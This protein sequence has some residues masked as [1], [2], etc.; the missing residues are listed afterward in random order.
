ML[1][2]S[3]LARFLLFHIFSWGLCLGLLSNS[4]GQDTTPPTVVSTYPA[5]GATNVRL[6]LESVSITFDR[7]M[8][9]GYSIS[10][11]FPYDS[12]SWSTDGQTFTLLRSDLSTPLLAG[13]TYTFTLNKD[14]STS[15]RD[16][17][18]VP[19]EEYTFSFTT[20]TNYE[21]L[22]IPANPASV[23]LSTVIAL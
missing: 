7:R 22:K 14:S 12:V 13:T 21:L 16:W 19:L 23:A 18:G 1:I 9:A 17:S 15:F 5:N 6:N 2:R 20:L 3:R 10:T 11:L 4:Y 8:R